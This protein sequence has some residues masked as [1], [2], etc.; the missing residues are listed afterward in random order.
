VLRPYQADCVERVRAAYRAGRRRVLLQSPTGS[1]KTV[2]F[3][4]ILQQM[5][6][7]GSRAA[8]LLH[9]R[10]LVDQV[11]RFLGSLDL[12]HG[13][14][15]AGYPPA[16]AAPVLVCSVPSLAHRIE[17]LAPADLVVVD[18]A[19]HSPAG[20]W[21]KIFDAWPGARVL[22][23]S[24]TPERLDGQ[25]LDDLYD[26]L[27]IG[28]SVRE[29]EEQGWLAPAVVYAA[30][31]P[32]LS[33]V[34]TV[35]G[36]YSAADLDHVMGEAGLIGNAVEHWQ[37]HAAGLPTIV[38]CV[39]IAHS[40][41]VCARFREAG[42]RARHVDGET[43]DEER[44]TAIAGLAGG[45]VQVLTNCGLISEGVDVPALGALVLLR[46]TAS[47]TLHLQMLGRAGRPYPGKTHSIILD[48][49]GNTASLGLPNDPHEWSLQGR[50][51][52]E[53]GAAP[54]KTCP[55]CGGAIPLAARVCPEC[56]V[57]LTDETLIPDETPG[58]LVRVERDQALFR[59]LRSWRYRQAV[60]WAGN[61]P[62]KIRLVGLA[63]GY[64]P[65]WAWHRI[66]EMASQGGAQ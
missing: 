15:A 55:E 59:R 2:V 54:D 36:D 56:G 3:T 42:T 53:T 12:E 22:G 13:I 17:R 16:A 38:F 19:H 46:P 29:L 64:K 47:L 32:D 43:P 52:N 45:T 10:E 37:R 1:G 57:V 61:D 62:D 66:R 60:R 24:A 26:E 7:R 18:E 8:I 63:R 27:V 34:R 41:A 31:P 40:Q 33:R 20:T 5:Q 51:R 44:R 39:S 11:D 49:A 4:F 30:P 35:A 28:P 48:H 65:G 6:H 21:R 50:G 9:R 14:V 23:V 58:E 25:G